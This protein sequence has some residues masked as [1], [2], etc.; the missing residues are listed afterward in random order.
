MSDIQF[1][2]SIGDLEINIQG[3]AE[4]VHGILN[5][6]RNEG[7]GKLEF[8]QAPMPPETDVVEHATTDIP[9]EVPKQTSQPQKQ[10]KSKKRTSA[11]PTLIKSLDLRGSDDIIGLNAFVEEKQ[12]KSNV[13]RTA[14]FVY[15]LEH[16][17]RINPITLDHIFT[18]Y[19]HAN[20]REPSN[21]EQNLR[22]TAS[23]KYGYI[24]YDKNEITTSVQG[25]NLVEHDLPE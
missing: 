22:D 19:K 21:L 11:K 3:E 6:L 5:E 14:V 2:L 23:S 4:V 20:I 12:P 10:G 17:Q 8:F 18:C 1:K 25:R 16:V 9:K 7:L 13:K 15:Y 24:N